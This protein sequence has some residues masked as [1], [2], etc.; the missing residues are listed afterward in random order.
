[1]ILSFL[2]SDIT[3]LQFVFSCRAV[4]FSRFFLILVVLVV[5]V[6]VETVCHEVFEYRGTFMGPGPPELL[7][8]PEGNSSFPKMGD[9]SLR[10]SQ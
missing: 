7:H 3:D 10:S 8:A 9:E 5:F 4:L 2:T 1:M 6:V